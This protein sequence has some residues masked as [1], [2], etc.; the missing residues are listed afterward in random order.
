LDRLQ[1]IIQCYGNPIWKIT[2]MFAED[3]LLRGGYA[4]WSLFK[5]PKI[6]SRPNPEDLGT[7]V[8]KAYIL[9][10]RANERAI[11]VPSEVVSTITNARAAVK[12][13]ELDGEL[14]T[15]FWNAYGLLNSSIEPAESARR[16]Y[17]AVFYCVLSVLLVSQF[18]YLGGASVRD[19]M[20]DIDKQIIEVRGRA[21]SAEAGSE[22]S[23]NPEKADTEEGV[24]SLEDRKAAYL[25][26]AQRFVGTA[27]TILDLPFRLFGMYSIINTNDEATNDIT[28]E[29]PKEELKNTLVIGKLEMLLAFFADYLLPMLYGL[30]GSCAF[31][32]RKLS[33]E[34]DKMTYAHDA[35]VRH[36][37]RLNVGLLA[38]LAVGWFLKPGAG[39]L[40]LTSLS[41]LALAFIAGYGSDLFFVFL[42][43]IV[44]TFA[45]TSG[46]ATATRTETTTGGITMVQTKE[47]TAHVAGDASPGN[48]GR[49][50]EDLAA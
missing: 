37:L 43:K 29:R 20:L 10:S 47:V 35:R 48:T 4:M 24:D 36:T 15:K 5:R 41:P 13:G 44:N 9:L 32:L 30:I 3:P 28:F 46:A 21:A 2:Q 6:S 34:I 1:P 50:Q 40:S 27:T 39:D 49:A 18:F 31:V 26:L 45:P 25:I 17:R 8:K 19:K 11:Q 7:H 16:I 23:T 33:D 42:D 38:G 22:S 12:N 14:E